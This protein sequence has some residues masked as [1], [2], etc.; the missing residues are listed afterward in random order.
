M[1]LSRGYFAPLCTVALAS[2]SRI[3]FLLLQLG[4]DGTLQLQRTLEW[5]KSEF[6]TLVTHGGELEETTG[7][8]LR[9]VNHVLSHCVVKSW[10]NLMNSFIELDNDEHISAMGKRRMEVILGRGSIIVSR[11]N[12]SITN[13][14]KDIDMSMG[15]FVEGNVSTDDMTRHNKSSPPHRNVDDEVGE[16]VDS[17]GIMK[18][19]DQE[20]TA[21]NEKKDDGDRNLEMIAILKGKNSKRKRERIDIGSEDKNLQ[22][23]KAAKVKDDSSTVV[24]IRSE[25]KEDSDKS[26]VRKKEKKTKKKKVKKKKKKS[27]DIIDD[28]FGD[29]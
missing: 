20:T 9:E 3:R 19:S 1:E 12:S 16:L 21:L 14:T 26:S 11:E 25:T 15:S 28:I 5:L 2:I 27:K 4:R 7:L 6:C 24:S 8:Y 18:F 10:E 29:L 23:K 13:G 17:S 22:S